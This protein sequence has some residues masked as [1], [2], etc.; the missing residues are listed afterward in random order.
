MD[1]LHV[2]MNAETLSKA[3]SGVRR[4]ADRWEKTYPKVVLWQRDEL[5][6]LLISLCY[7]TLEERKAVRSCDT[8]MQ[9]PVAS[10]ATSSVARKSLPNPS[11]AV[12]VIS[13]RPIG[14][15]S[16]SFQ[17]TTPKVR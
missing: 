2:V 4:F 5:D 6:G 11:S 12:R 7:K 15:S 10:S 13:M 14:R 1:D 8:A 17:T 3:R 16:P 9:M